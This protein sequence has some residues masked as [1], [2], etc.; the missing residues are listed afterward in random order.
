MR[1]VLSLPARVGRKWGE[2]L[3]W[4]NMFYCCTT[5]SSERNI[6]T[7][8]MPG[9][10]HVYQWTCTRYVHIHKDTHLIPPHLKFRNTVSISP[11]DFFVPGKISYFFIVFGSFS[12]PSISASSTSSSYLFCSA[13]FHSL[14]CIHA[15]C[16]LSYKDGPSHH[17]TITNISVSN[18]W[19]QPAC[20]ECVHLKDCTTALQ[21]HWNNDLLFKTLMIKYGVIT[22]T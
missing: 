15:F 13:Y 14:V 11:W 8:T 10:V 3:A 9:G 2:Y 20:V 17:N 16:I 4:R 7:H 21:V 5:C 22:Y 18:G 1:W 19:Q 12:F 6:S